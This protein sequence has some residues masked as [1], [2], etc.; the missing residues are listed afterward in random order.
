MKKVIIFFIIF[1]ISNIIIFP[2][3]SDGFFFNEPNILSILVSLI[4]TIIFYNL[5][6]EKTE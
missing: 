2:I 4:L 5:Y 6:I 3:W 1:I